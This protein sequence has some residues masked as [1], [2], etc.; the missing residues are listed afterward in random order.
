ML[1]YHLLSQ[2]DYVNLLVQMVSTE[3]GHLPGRRDLND[4]QITIGF[5]YTFDRNDNVAL[6][7][8]A[9]ISLTGVE[10]NLLGRIDVASTR[11]ERNALALQFMRRINKD[12]AIALL[13]QTYPQYE[14]PANDLGMPPSRERAAFVSIVYN[15]GIPAV[16]SK[17][18]NFF[19]SVLSAENG[20]AEAWFQIRYNANALA[21]AA[22]N[23]NPTRQQL[24][25]IA[26]G[27]DR[28]IA[29]RRYYESEVFGLYDNAN[30][31]TDPTLVSLDEANKIY[32]MLQ[33]HREAIT[34]Y[35]DQYGGQVGL[36]NFDYRL[37]GTPYEVKSLVNELLS[38]QA[39]LFDDLGSKYTALST[40]DSS[41][42]TSISV[43][44]DPGRDAGQG[45]D[46]FDPNHISGLIASQ[47]TTAGNEVGFRDV[48]IGEGG[49]D[50]L[51]GGKG[52]DILLG[53]T[54][55]DTYAFRSG[56][57]ADRLIDD[58]GRGIL[59]RDGSVL[60]LGIGQDASTWTLG[61]VTYSKTSG[62]TLRIGF[63]G[64]P[65]VITIE[66]F[67]F[68]AAQAGGYLG[69]R[70][71][72]KREDPAIGR[73][74]T[75]D[76]APID[77]DPVSPGVQTDQDD[78][79]N[80]IVGA[81]A[82]PDRS[83]ILYD[84]TGNDRILAKGGNDQI[85]AMRGGDDRIEAGAG[86]DS[87]NGGVGKDLIEGGGD[88]TFNGDVGGDILN[89]GADNDRLYADT[90]IELGQAIEQGKQNNKNAKKGD[91]I[92]G[93]VG[94]DWVVG[95]KE[96][97]IL[98]GGP[99]RDLVVGGAGDDVI[100][101]DLVESASQIDWQLT[102]EIRWEGMV[103]PDYVVNLL[104]IHYQEGQ[105]ID[106]GDA[107]VIY[108]GAGKDVIYG[109][110]GNDF[111]DA[112]SEDD[113]V[114]GGAGEDVL[115]GGTGDDILAG[116]K[117]APS[118]TDSADYLD[119]GEGV[120]I[121]YGGGGDDVLIGGS[122]HDI[123]IGGTGK[124]T[125]IFNRG[126]GVEI[127]TDTSDTS[128]SAERSVIIFG[129][130]V[131]REEVV[132]HLGSLMID[133]GGGDAI[134]FEGF[135]SAD[136][137]ST[138]LLESML[139]ADGSSMSYQDILDQ[140][141]DID[142]TEGDDNDELGKQLALVG[143]AVTD[144]IRG[145]AGDD[146]LAGRAGNDMLDGGAGNDNLFGEAGTDLLDGGIGTDYL[147]GGEGD[148]LYLLGLGDGQDFIQDLEGNNTVRFGA[149]ISPE[150]IGVSQALGTD[151]N[152]YLLL[153]YGSDQLFV[154]NGL[155]GG[156]AS[157]E[158]SDGSV[159]TQPQ[160]FARMPD[161]EMPVVFGSEEADT[162]E[163]SV[164]AERFV[165]GDGDDTVVFGYGSAIDQV[166]DFR[167]HAAR[168][169]QPKQT[170]RVQLGAGITSADLWVTRE[171]QFNAQTSSL[172]L[173]L[174]NTG[175]RLTLFDWGTDNVQIN[176][177]LGAQ[178]LFANGSAW[179]PS[180]LLQASLSPTSGNDSM[181]GTEGA[182]TLSGGAG[183]DRLFG[184]NPINPAPVGGNDTLLGGEGNDHL[185][186]LGGND[187]LE[188]GAGDDRLSGDK[189]MDIYRFG[190][191][192]GHD[193]V[194][195][196]GYA[197]GNLVQF[198]TDIT[199]Q[200]V[201]LS[202][203][204]AS[205]FYGEGNIVHADPSY[206]RT[207]S[208]I[209]SPNSIVVT[210]NS[211]GETLTLDG[212]YWETWE[213]GRP[214]GVAT[215]LPQFTVDTLRFA[216]GT[217]WDV[218]MIN[219]Q[220]NHATPSADLL[221]GIHTD[222]TLSGLGGDDVMDGYLGDDVLAGGN[223]NDLLRGGFGGD[224]LDG[225]AGADI[226]EGGQGFDILTGG[227]GNDT[228]DGG[229]GDDV[230]LVGSGEDII[231]E[232]SGGTDLLVLP[233]NI[234]PGDVS[235]WQNGAGELIL[236]LG[237]GNRI[238]L[239]LA[240]GNDLRSHGIEEFRFA[241]GT[242]WNQDEL[243]A[244]RVA[245]PG[246]PANDRLTG[247]AG[248]DTIDAGS[249]GD[250]VEGSFG[251]D[252]LYGGEGDDQIFSYKQFAFLP[253]PL[254]DNAANQLF[255]GAGNDE[256]WGSTGGDYLQGDQGNDS[257]LGG[258][259]SDTLIGGAGSDSISGGSGNDFLDGGAG[260]DDLGGQFGD[261]TYLFGRDSGHDTI[262]QDAYF[263][264]KN[265]R[266]GY[267]LSH[268]INSIE[269]DSL[270]GSGDVT[271]SR[272]GA[273]LV[274]AAEDATASITVWNWLDQQDPGRLE[275]RFADGTRWGSAA[276]HALSGA[277]VASA[278]N[279]LILGFGTS[280][281][282]FGLGGDDTIKG[283]AGDDVLD[284][285]S[286]ND[287]LS[288]GFGSDTYLFGY[289]SGQDVISE[290]VRPDVLDQAVMGER[291]RIVFGASV[292]PED[293]IV[294]FNS[295]TEPVFRL[296][297]SQD[298]LRISGWADTVNRVEF[299]EF[300][301]GT[302][303]DLGKFPVWNRIN[304]TTLDIASGSDRNF[305]SASADS[306]NM[307]IHDEVFFGLSGNDF[308]GDGAGHDVL[309]G[310]D[311]ND[312]LFWGST[313]AGSG[314]GL[315]DGGAGNDVLAPGSGDNVIHFGRG[316]GRDT[317][318]L[319]SLTGPF[320]S[321]NNFGS[322]T[323]VLGQDVRPEHVKL[324]PESN[325]GA[326]LELAGTPDSLTM[327]G[328]IRDADG[329]S[330]VR[331]S[332][333]DGTFWD[334]GQIEARFQLVAVVEGGSGNN[335][336]KGGPGA[337]TFIGGEGNDTLNGAEGADTFV[338][339]RGDGQ[340]TIVDQY[341]RILLGT[342]IR[343]QDVTLSMTSLEFATAD[344]QL[345]ISAGG[346][347]I[348]VKDWFSHDGMD[349][350][351]EFADGTSW[352]ATFVGARLP[353]YRLVSSTWVFS[354]TPG[355]DTFAGGAQRDAMY[356]RSGN[357]FLTGN[358][359]SDQILGG[360]GN[361]TLAGNAGEDDLRGEAGDDTLVGGIDRDQLD[362]GDGNDT[363]EG[364]VDSLAA[365]EF[366]DDSLSGG[367]G[368]DR[369]IG[370]AGDDNL[371]G[372]AGDDQLDGGAGNDM[373]SGGSGVDSLIGGT[374]NDELSGGTDA[375][376]LS[377]GAGHDVLEG[378]SGDDLIDGGA[379]DDHLYGGAGSDT[380]LFG[381]GSGH[382]TLT[383]FD[384]TG[385]AVDTVRLGLGIGPADISVAQEGAWLVLRILASGESLTI[386]TLGLEG[387]GV[388]RVVFEDGS[389]WSRAQLLD[390]A[391]RSAPT[392]RDDVILGGGNAET[393][394]GL[395][396]DDLVDGLGGDDVL[397][398]G[399]GDD[400]VMGR[401]GSDTL[402]GG[403]GRDHL[404]GGEGNDTFVVSIG[405]G[406]DSVA[407]F[408]AGDTLAFGVGIAP[409]NVRIARDFANLY[410]TLNVTGQVVTLENWFANGAQGSVAF[411]DGT[412]WDG[413]F[414]K[415]RVDALTGNDDFFVGTTASELIST[416]GGFD[417]VF[418][419]AGND[420]VLGGA[421]SDVLY[422][423][424]GDDL[425]AGEEGSDT[426]YGGDG[427]DLLDGG[428]GDDVLA[429]GAGADILD[430][431]D[432]DDVVRGDAGGDTL[433]GGLGFDTLL[434]GEGADILE[435]GIGD[436]V[437]DG[438]SGSDS[439]VFA[440]GFGTDVV[441]EG[442]P[443]NNLEPNIDTLRLA[444]VAPG[445]VAL[446]WVGS[447]IQ[448]EIAGSTDR[449]IFRNPDAPSFPFVIERVQFD[450]GTI[451]NQAQI[452]AH[453]SRYLTD[454]NDFTA[455]GEYGGLFGLGGNDSLNGFGG[456]DLLDGGDG[457]DILSGSEGNDVLLGGRGVDRLDGGDGN[458]LLDG[459]NDNDLL[460]GGNGND[461]LRGGTGNDSLTD[462]AGDDVLD[463]GT[464]NDS[465]TGGSGDDT[466]VFGVGYGN[467]SVSNFDVASNR[468]DV[469]VLNAGVSPES[470]SIERSTTDLIVLVGNQADRLTISGW[471]SSR[472]QQLNEARFSN[473]TVWS[474][475]QIEARIAPLVATGGDDVLLGLSG[476]DTVDGLGG[477][478]RLD[479]GLGNDTL[480]G[481]AGNDTILGGSGQDTLDG[482][483]G[484]DVLEG[485]VG[486]D[487]YVFGPGSGFD[488]ISDVDATAGN[489]DVVL[490][491]ALAADVTITRNFSNLQITL[492]GGVERLTLQSWFSDDAQRIEEV[493]LSDGT[494]WDVAAL[495]ALANGLPI[496][497]RQGTNGA[498]NLVGTLGADRLDGLAGDDTIDG[499]GGND[500]LFGGGDNDALL[501]RAGN[502]MLD[503]GSGNDTLNGG[504]GD[505]LY[506]FA[507]GYGVDTISDFDTTPGNFDTIEVDGMA[508]DARIRRAGAN[509]EIYLASGDI[510]VS[511]GWFVDASQRIERVRFTDGTNWDIAT[512]DLM[513]NAGF[514]YIGTDNA[515]F[516]YGSDG[517]DTLDGLAGNDVLGGFSGDDLLRG[518]TGFDTLFG[519]AGNDELTGGL[520]NDTIYGDLGDDT[521]RFAL[522]DGSDIL[523]ET[524]GSDTVEFGVGITPAGVSILRAGNDLV[525][526]LSGGGDQVSLS[527]WF[528]SAASKIEQVQFVDGTV[529]NEGFLLFAT[530][531]T[532][533]GDFIRGSGIDDHIDALGGDDSVFG[534]PGN[535]ELKGGAGDDALGG[536]DGADIL[537]GGAGR[538]LLFGDLGADR[539]IFNTGYGDDWI[540][541]SGGTDEVVFGPGMMPAGLVFTRDLSNLYV[542]AGAD[543]L[544]LVDWF[545]RPDSRVESFRFNDGTVLT[546]GA[547]RNRIRPA[548]ASSLDDTIF[549]SDSNDVLSGLSGE[550]TLYGEAG[551]DIL[552]G[553]SGSDY[554]I[555]GRGNDAY[556]VD[557]RLDRISEDSGEGIDTVTSAASYVVPANVENLTLSGS[558][559]INGVGNLLDNVIVGNAAANL[560]DGGLG[561]DNLRGGAGNDSYIFRLADGVDEIVDLDS[562]T[563]NQDEVRFDVGITP[564]QVLVS[565]I[566]DDIR[567]RVV[568]G[569]EVYLR[570]WFNPAY[571]IESVRF[572]D[573]TTWD[574]PTIEHLSTQVI[575]RPPFVVQNVDDRA[576]SEDAAFELTV[577]A[578][579]FADPDA[580]D[581]LTY[582]ATL[583]DGTSLP[584]WLSFDAATRTFSG[585]PVNDDVGR[586]NV[587]LSVTDSGGLSASSSFAINV[588]NVNDPP[589]A[590]ADTGAAVEDGGAVILSEANLL[591]NDSDSDTLHGDTLRIIGVSQSV[592]GASVSLASGAVQYYIGNLYQTLGQGQTATDTFSYTI[593][594]FAGA[595]SSATVT[596]TIAGVN[597]APDTVADHNSV[598]E[599]VILAAI[600]NVLNND[601]DIDAGSVLAV[602][603]AD[604]GV[605][606][607]SYG[608][609]TL[610]ADGSYSYALNNT[611]AAVQ[612]LAAGQTVTDSFS[613]RASDGTAATLSLL[614][615]RITGS[616]DGPQL[617][618][619][620]AAATE[621]TPL[622]VTGNVLANDTDKDLGDVLSVNNAGAH[623]GAHGSLNL[624]S[625]GAYS[626]LVNRAQLQYLR[627]GESVSDVFAYGATDGL[628]SA[629]SQLAVTVH[630][631]NDAPVALNDLASTHEDATAP[632]TGNVLANDQDVDHDTVLRVT[633]A[634]PYAGQYGTLSLAANGS[635]SY[636]V[637]N[638]A[639]QY[640]A[641]GQSVMEQFAVQI[642]DDDPDAPLSAA[643]NL[644]ITIQGA[645]EAVAQSKILHIENDAAVADGVADR[646]GDL[647]N[648]TFAVTNLGNTAIANV[649]VSDPLT[650]NEAPVLISG[651]NAGDANRDNLLDV[652]ETWQFSA[653]HLLTQSEL[654][655]GTAIVNTATAT[656]TGAIS[657]D[658][659]ASVMVIQL[660]SLSINTVTVYGAASGDGLSG[661]IAGNSIGWR[662]TVTN[663]GNVSLSGVSVKDNAGTAATSDDL[664]AT[665]VLSGG[666]NA[667]DTN[668]D[669]KLS[670][671]E[672][673]QFTASGNAVAGGYNNFGTANASIGAVSVTGSDSSSYFGT[674][675]AAQIAPTGTTSNQYISGAAP[676]F[677]TYYNSLGGNIQ[678]NVVNSIINNTNPGVFFYY[679]GLSNTI[680]G[681]D[682]NDV[683]TAPDA[684]TVK[685]D[686]S[687]S[688]P[689]LVNTLSGNTEWNFSAMPD[690]VKLY[691]VIDAD[692]DGKIDP[693]ESSV[694]VQLPSSQ[695]VFGSGANFG[696]VTL[697]FTPDAVGSL[698]VIGVKY[699]TS[700]VN[701]LPASPPLT[702]N[703]SFNTDVGG[704]GSIEET[705]VGGITLA[706]KPAALTI[707]GDNGNNTLI[708]GAGD[709][710]INGRGGTDTMIGGMGDDTYLVDNIGDV[711]TELFNE[712]T[713]LI[714]TSVT[715]A[716][717]APN[718]ENLTL[719]GTSALS[720]TGNALDNVLAGNSAN[721][722]LTGGTGNDTLIG[723]AGTDTTNGGLGDDIHVVDATADVTNENANEGNDTIQSSVTRTLAANFENLILT[724]TGAINATGNAVANL[725]LG[726]S[727]VNTLSGAAGN[728]ILQ[729]LGGNDILTDS[730]GNGLYDG[731]AG[732]DTLTGGANNEMFIGGTGNDTHTT[733]TGADVIAFNLGDGLD[734]VNA[735]TAA[736][737]TVSLGG[738]L[739]YAGLSFTKATNDLVLNVGATDKLTFKDWYAGTGNRSVAKL[740]VVTEGM[741][742]FALGGADPLL[743]NKIETFN[744]AALASAFDAAGQVN[745]WS[746]MN[747]M[748]S[749]HLS[750]SD[751]EA[752]GGDLAYQYGRNGSLANIGLTPAQEVINAPGFGSGTQALRPIA[753]LQQGQIRL[754]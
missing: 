452:N 454:G 666:L 423:E 290:Y 574:A 266:D 70:L 91:F 696:D 507:A 158:F 303:W 532:E 368:N 742:G 130:G 651:F 337:E 150:E 447:E 241:D 391:S 187:W 205:G 87:V 363:L 365:G 455:I 526:R 379:E 316:A 673:W 287:F 509:L 514:T 188:G 505:D 420:N 483:I 286:G 754:G 653:S 180:D 219:E 682:G 317:L 229:S 475:A 137:Y 650:T 683:G 328:G 198:G 104:G 528:A 119:G 479:G 7:R 642:Q 705:S 236:D 179:L 80:V 502:D 706:P 555:G 274:V 453:T 739:S 527:G 520:E 465:L 695:I 228:L 340:D 416:L 226:L 519:G 524:G 57:G 466:Y 560:L 268:E 281:T 649:Q 394:F 218:S 412:L 709:D 648:Y 366:D 94:D 711:V 589:V 399:V 422:G 101:G 449:L 718:V 609:L 255:G 173:T 518:G 162:L 207:Q 587:T 446:K 197:E 199:P 494:V 217:T 145:F 341:P 747:A 120:D 748:L 258:D 688:G 151:G 245:A 588:S 503:G 61:D 307:G 613:Y 397:L 657:D 737:N 660:P 253:E 461:T 203:V 610:N 95:D 515:D 476:G 540:L 153:Y 586:L 261:D 677:S 232:F 541:D 722:T 5:G 143:T 248:N 74:I 41:D 99:G 380:Y 607:G 497:P 139:F 621:D 350:T 751:T 12:E 378:G 719:T 387:Y 1:N 489:V 353:F 333:A 58:D 126:D 121:L 118:A 470:V 680:K 471:F 186:G 679:T 611:L 280:E 141:F 62:N 386:R 185:A 438:G 749:L 200:G 319:P 342:G 516:L 558:A 434:G 644:I 302:V 355:G 263:V 618:A 272:A 612:A 221:R 299:A 596:M 616:N 47:Y 275:L 48:L 154:Q 98:H 282:L 661:V 300:A 112:G 700:S 426:L 140:G 604:I 543:R 629:Q 731:G 450:D 548:L 279:D 362:G 496:G 149:G 549:G 521:F 487:V 292:R 535:D 645:D 51:L 359:G 210:L 635:Y 728:D 492:T 598:Q 262:F 498:D 632:L 601:S 566:V 733:G 562:T 220:A 437:L 214:F 108:A 227:E 276:L 421:D 576:A 488:T 44:L 553:G 323:I 633:N 224:Q 373:L 171:P 325:G 573:G 49:N 73:T 117:P 10:I 190:A 291:D 440:P 663:N 671:G 160:M 504:A 417:T 448:L 278:G 643:S 444:G 134:H 702:V 622:A 431:G 125:Y 313:E 627:A 293:V 745:Q 578:N 664:V 147:L 464:G 750:G 716:T 427:N 654:D 178:V 324:R 433:G 703:Y 63:T 734:V 260:N 304:A 631:L 115:I 577:P 529:W 40:L 211:T 615:V 72:D 698:Y 443:L 50:Y 100:D 142:G 730:G 727:A 572:A 686:Q 602:F 563:G 590:N 97:D 152:A 339:E 265:P 469:L 85:D 724:G 320:G 311:G 662:Y 39:V 571:K 552:D 473:N 356:G 269:V 107:D 723:G 582:S 652:N 407:D 21:L 351:I 361:D 636:V 672:T 383:D 689:D 82:E 693:N 163:G 565:R 478:D 135:D 411:A 38:A 102:R 513:A 90:K 225:G 557:H 625:D 537:D 491:N 251:A 298:T 396:G 458:D 209:R 606:T 322:Q 659:G 554:L 331:L 66:N 4:N 481:N 24:I 327:S 568:G 482:G 451:W 56:D 744:F 124:D 106:A 647:I 669:G 738:A 357:D 495:S 531:V 525:L 640:L 288:G 732:T 20:R 110:G 17:M 123:L 559:A 195:A 370:R 69:I 474:A 247:T 191:G 530:S 75:G 193:I 463:G 264:L 201:T 594:D 430:G 480:F 569:G 132:F 84:S 305:G 685:I 740:Q 418:A 459:G 213:D 297:G 547:V 699:D 22:I 295:A 111:I 670:V 3:E 60:A 256:L 306:P 429:G 499:Q 347:Q 375:D 314:D 626:Y 592:G 593:A 395:G 360:E 729:G 413:A 736:D 551:D 330:R 45:V 92:Y 192:D 88:G 715:L 8:A 477:N 30:A 86:R 404:A 345:T 128:N 215:M 277:A 168:A 335:V 352:D 29:K 405:S 408:S 238:R 25:Q 284:G 230:Y 183:H 196:S 581:T 175:E 712:G 194:E 579:T 223:G 484:D 402:D 564:S 267:S 332:F 439:Y 710:I 122:D 354:G 441:S 242:T 506:R 321:K 6:W 2:A 597:D 103:V 713:D 545:A 603:A 641:T 385:S 309:Y 53:G 270:L 301:D 435:G 725:L 485:G 393:L 665:A 326:I 415:A 364:G 538:D 131:N 717:L 129:P 457:A 52:D 369:L 655:A 55:K 33:F 315:Y 382:D 36:A 169:G 181:I 283:N 231:R 343:P 254:G 708:G 189:G 668:A 113:Y 556:L 46:V 714:Q 630:G 155:L 76:L 32:R 467:D 546:E 676:D 358:G 35:E 235:V 18:G 398:G 445:L 384:V 539:F 243:I 148:D 389:E 617:N 26:E 605:R 675:D 721:N 34:K 346:G 127:I 15:R 410:L 400:V 599:D 13:K 432:G 570:N 19:A 259:G 208:D 157:Y 222:D 595:T 425:L 367:A 344:L 27:Q 743:N 567:L 37:A 637:N 96:S 414:L 462:G 294:E 89:G 249:G 634:G 289:S 534:G 735:S 583:A 667:G 83:D 371:S 336:L 584:S 67:D 511:T 542:A 202:F 184:D 234:L 78:L 136:P 376:V 690:D 687:N 456:N 575:N 406:S 244:R 468:N 401:A 172:T 428:I 114:Y 522:G 442:N 318:I 296:A 403:A 646:V 79:G 501:G 165:L 93:G 71:E 116:D 752:L 312:S 204:E 374:G 144:R 349:G 409:A 252:I 43:Y 628:V 348:I 109:R 486:N 510:L 701:G 159:L 271:V 16:T 42:Y 273:N 81:S 678:Y 544:T 580:G 591:A 424:S 523:F 460:F 338:F 614:N 536:E 517:S 390:R 105:S 746:L 656:G 240:S 285:G 388:E 377:G 68:A 233:R 704:D 167:F 9:G 166:L 133:L 691:K 753:D 65:D 164:L 658:D 77:T 239:A 472:E 310:G 694:Q 206:Y 720:A 174:K 28:G 741:A 639:V 697:T 533:S 59:A 600:G 146:A 692:G 250:F 500:V 381:I 216:D 707:N 31:F 329:A 257:L 392:D 436:D 176:D 419:A 156:V 681:F 177:S 624:A 212:W 608:N 490:L 585:T 684:M 54:G 493:R 372:D 623:T 14:G 726:N 512:L 170:D 561:N 550:D 638:A 619:D 161:F 508:S 246:T 182:D 64:S 334:A 11:T 674:A 23:G 138:P 237:L 308:L 620:S